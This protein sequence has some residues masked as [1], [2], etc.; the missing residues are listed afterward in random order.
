[1]LVKNREFA[2]CQLNDGKKCSYLGNFLLGKWTRY[3]NGMEK[4]EIS[5]V[6]SGNG[7]VEDLNGGK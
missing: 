4:Q 2:S 5:L 6:T 1:M 3:N 7:T